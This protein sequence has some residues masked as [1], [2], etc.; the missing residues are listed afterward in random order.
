MASFLLTLIF[1]WMIC[2]IVVLVIA[3]VAIALGAALR[4]VGN[5]CDALSRGFV[6]LFIRARPTYPTFTEPPPV[7]AATPYRNPLDEAMGWLIGR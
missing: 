6:H 5:A 7:P 1:W 4:A 2:G 3:A